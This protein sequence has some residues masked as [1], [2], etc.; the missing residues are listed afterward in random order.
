VPL[1]PPRSIGPVPTVTGPIAVTETSAPFRSALARESSLYVDLHAL[2]YVE[3]EWL[4]E[5]TADAVDPDGAVL[6]EDAPYVTRVLVRRPRDP[7]QCSGAVFV[8][9]FHN[10]NEDTPAWTS[11]FRY[12][13]R[14]GHTWVGLTVNSGTFGPAGTARGG[15]VAQLREFDPERYARLHLL[16]FEHGPARAAPPGP[17]GFD[18]ELMR[19][20][21]AIATAQGHSIAAGLF[22]LL[23]RNDPRSPLAGFPVW[24]LYATGWSQTGLFLQQFLDRGYHEA[25]GDAEV[26]FGRAEGADPVVDGYLIAV[27][28]APGHRPADAVLVNL[29]SEGEVVGTLSPGF[30]V[31]DD[32]DTPRFRG[33]EVPGSFHHWE[34]KPGAARLQGNG[35]RGSEHDDLHNDRPW[36]VV[37]HAILDNL[38]R[39]V[40]DGVPMPH[41][42]RIT[43]D[44]AAPDGV[45]RDEYGNARGGLR[46][47]WLDVPTAR[48]AP[49]C[50]CSPVTGSMTPLSGDELR[51]RYRDHDAF[52]GAW[53]RSIDSLVADRWLLAEDAAALRAGSPFG[54]EVGPE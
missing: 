1:S 22:G 51:A 8:E 42:S 54:P 24:R 37:V 14:N 9:P 3:E 28:P 19:W 49:R 23:K 33:Y 41:A 35:E 13:I 4:L 26:Q 43:R 44:P 29:V 17:G 2:G 45:A 30:V 21:L 53:E 6:E 27:G 36:H 50:T 25:M 34:V 16:A 15:G 38:D 10:L 32:T 5:G 40:R 18:P 48:Y 52:V 12:L 11:E 47:P 39:W 31:P 7:A 20:R 46:T